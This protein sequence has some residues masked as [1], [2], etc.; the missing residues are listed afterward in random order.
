MAID[1][2]LL[3]PAR[4]SGHSLKTTV[5]AAHRFFTQNQKNTEASFEII[6]IP[7]ATTKEMNDDSTLTIANDLC[8][9]FSEVKISLHSG[10]VGKGAALKTG[11]L[12]CSGKM[13]FFTDADLPYDL[14]FFTH[15]IQ[16]LNSGYE[17]VTGN[18]RLSKSSFQVPV[19]LLPL[20]YKRHRL[21]LW[22]NSIV[23]LLLHIPTTDTQAGIKAMTRDLAHKAFSLQQCSFF[24]FDLEL[25]LTALRNGYTHCELPVTLY[26][27]SEKSTVRVFKESL[28]AAYWLAK[29]TWNN[30]K[31]YYGER[32][33]HPPSLLSYYKN[34]DFF[35][36]IFLF[37]RWHLTPYIKMAEKIPEKGRILDMGCGHGLFSLLLAKH[38]KERQITGIDHDEQRIQF[39]KHALKHTPVLNQVHFQKSNFQI[40]SQ[41]SPYQGIALIDVMHYFPYEE[42]RSLLKETFKNL[43]NTGRLILREVDS[44]KGIISS[45]NKVYEKLATRLGFTQ[46][47]EVQLFFRN[48]YEW[49]TL[50][51]EIGYFVRSEPCS[52]F[53]FSDVLFICEKP[54]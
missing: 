23:R 19:E 37:L 41:A 40:P 38:S 46:S 7:N 50:L 45:W 51:R 24:F 44:K 49:E 48:R 18:R 53:L 12:A 35:T 6:L 4:R 11:F 1:I 2:S 17:L 43:E 34:T 16:K 54:L 21:G 28:S 22:F 32:P 14:E 10:P 29:I 52:H 47:Q 30:S 36:R 20:A 5:E 3:I 42:Q 26:L 33:T 15:A 27:N 39:A 8:R 9:R 31:N 25:F 13:I